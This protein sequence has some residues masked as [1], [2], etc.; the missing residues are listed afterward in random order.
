MPEPDPFIAALN[1]TAVRDALLCSTGL[2]LFGYFIGYPVPVKLAAFI[3]LALAGY[4]ISRQP[5]LLIRAAGDLTKES[6]T[7][8][9]LLYVLAGFLMGLAAAFYYRGSYSMP[10]L[11]GFFRGFV[12]IAVCI[13]ILEELVFR[14]FIQGILQGR[15]AGLAIGIAALAHACYKAALFLSP[16][17]EGSH[18]LYLFFTW[19]LGAFILLGLLR[20]YSRSLLPPVIV[21]AVFDLLVYAENA[22]APWWVW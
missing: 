20:Y 11:P 21:H 9:L 14:G 10:L 16:A 4:I 1:K 8:Q 2:V 18:P 12:L 6:S 7:V 19:S 13:G 15:H 3:P 17:A 22:E 5:G